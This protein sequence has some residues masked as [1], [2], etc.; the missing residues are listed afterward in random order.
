[1]PLPA[2][3]TVG[4]TLNPICDDADCSMKENP[5]HYVTIEL[6]PF[7][8]ATLQRAA[9]FL[10][11]KPVLDAFGDKGMDAQ[12]HHASIIRDDLL[13]ILRADVREQREE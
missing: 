10:A 13:L 3:Y 8:R 9:R 6:S 5:D 12:I 11:S 7:V 4:V 1:M 2:L